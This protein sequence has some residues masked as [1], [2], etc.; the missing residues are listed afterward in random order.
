[1]ETPTAICAGVAA[2]IAIVART[3]SAKSVTIFIR[4]IIEIPLEI[5]CKHLAF[6]AWVAQK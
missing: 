1:M 4:R 6:C 5:N 2:G 3:T